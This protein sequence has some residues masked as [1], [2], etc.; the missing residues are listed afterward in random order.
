MGTAFIRDA[1]E[2]SFIRCEG[3]E[4]NE[5]IRPLLNAVLSLTAEVERIREMVGYPEED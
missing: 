3:E 1:I 5:S 4:W 2:T